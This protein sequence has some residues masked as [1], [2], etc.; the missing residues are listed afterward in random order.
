MTSDSDEDERDD[1]IRDDEK[2]K[3]RRAKEEGK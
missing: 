1:E 3:M 2:M